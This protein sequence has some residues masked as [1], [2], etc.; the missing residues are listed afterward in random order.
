[1]TIAIKGIECQNAR[2][3]LRRIAAGERGVA[4]SVG[5]KVL[6]VEQAQAQRIEA[7]RVGFAY[8]VDHEMPDG[9]SRILTI[10]VND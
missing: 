1:M 8:L 3:A 5:G 7:M 2:E 10:P 9:T 6:V 4:I